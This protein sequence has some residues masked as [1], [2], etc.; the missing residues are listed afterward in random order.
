MTIFSSGPR[1]GG[2]WGGGI[3]GVLEEREVKKHEIF[4]AAFGNH[5][6]ETYFTRPGDPLLIFVRML[7]ASKVLS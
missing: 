3:G 6:F 7:E 4:K 1:T 5:L 2:I